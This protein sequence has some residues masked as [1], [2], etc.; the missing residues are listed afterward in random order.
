MK[1]VS[2]RNLFIATDFEAKMQQIEKVLKKNVP[3]CIKRGM[4]GKNSPS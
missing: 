2:K 1:I 3:S 4:N